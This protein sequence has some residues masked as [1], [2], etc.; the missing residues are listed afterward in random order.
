LLKRPIV[1]HATYSIVTEPNHRK[2]HVWNSHGHVASEL[3]FILCVNSWRCQCRTVTLDPADTVHRQW[4]GESGDQSAEWPSV[5]C[6]TR[7]VHLSV[8]S[9]S[10]SIKTGHYIIGDNWTGEVGNITCHGFCWKF[11][12]LQ[13][14]ENCENCL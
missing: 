8:M 10:W 12:S 7:C 3:L 4:A 13:P 11:N 5:T 14:C 9:T 1:L 6:L 2:F